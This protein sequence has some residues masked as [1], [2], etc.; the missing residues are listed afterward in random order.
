MKKLYNG[1]GK[2]IHPSP[3]PPSPFDL[4]AAL[5]AAILAVAAALSPEEKEVLAYLLS[6]GAIAGQDRV[7]GKKNTRQHPPELGCG[8]FGCYKSFWARWDASPN[9]HLIHQILDAVEESVEPLSHPSGRRR[10]RFNRHKEESFPAAEEMM[11]SPA[12]EDGKDEGFK[13]EEEEEEEGDYIDI[14]EEND[15]EAVAAGVHSSS[16]VRRF[17]SFVGEKIWGVWN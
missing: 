11:S 2:K 8:C 7:A 9:R 13:E 12:E 17:V 14:E 5:P 4:L 10:R 15:N 3:P 6:G 1:K 16:T